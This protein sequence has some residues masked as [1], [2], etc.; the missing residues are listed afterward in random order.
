MSAAPDER[1]AVSDFALT[2]LAAGDSIALR[3]LVGVYLPIEPMPKPAILNCPFSSIMTT[4]SWR[5]PVV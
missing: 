2:L 1:L 5:A 3:I 4:P